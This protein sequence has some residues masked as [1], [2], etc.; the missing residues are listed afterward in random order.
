MANKI[1]FRFR[2]FLTALIF[3]M[4]GGQICFA[5]T[6]WLCPSDPTTSPSDYMNLF[7]T[8]YDSQWSSAR[9][10]IKVFKIYRGFIDRMLQKSPD[11]LKLLFANLKSRGIQ[12]ALEWPALTYQ[13]VNLGGYHVEGFAEP[14]AS[15]TYAAKL[16]SLGADLAYLALDEPLYYGHFYTGAH[17][18]NGAIPD[19]AA[20]AAENLKQFKAVYPSIKIGDIEPVEAIPGD[21]FKSAMQEWLTLF[22]FKYGSSFAF[23]HADL[24][25]KTEWPKRIAD[26]KPL[27]Q[28]T[29]SDPAISLGVIFNSALS[30]VAA[31]VWLHDAEV[32]IQ[33]YN[34]VQTPPEHVIF[35]NWTNSALQLMPDSSPQSYLSLVNYYYLPYAKTKPP[36]ELDRLKKDGHRIFSSDPDEIKSLKLQGWELEDGKGVG[37]RIYSGTSVGTDIASNSPIWQNAPGLVALIRISNEAAN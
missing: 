25:W 15:A 23:V 7:N 22:R 18:L 17:A 36:F 30:S 19:L 16:K 4:L 13:G 34:S 26:L 20:N 5:E 29:S 33:T 27:L 6:A 10:H 35:Q 3:F 14:N 12:L 28:A 32:N 11:D 8:S 1:T 9:S 2:I 24:N 37:L 21:Q 31:P